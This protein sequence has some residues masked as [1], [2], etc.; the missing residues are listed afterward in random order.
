MKTKHLL[1]A[2]FILILTPFLWGQ[3]PQTMSYQGVLTD[4]N[5]VPV[6]DGNYNVTFRLYEGAT[7]GNPLWEE[8]QLIAATSGIFNVILGRVIPL[9]L[10]F[11]NPYWLG[12]TVAA[13]SE[14]TPRIQLTSSAYSLNAADAEKV[15]GFEVSA[16]P[17][18]N[19]LL[20][21][22]DSGKFPT[23]VLP[24]ISPVNIGGVQDPSTAIPINSTSNIGLLSFTISD[25]GTFN[26]FLN[27]HLTAE[28]LGDGTGQY[29]FTIRRGSLDG[30]VLGR[31]NW[32]PGSAEG[33][34]TV[35][36]SFTGID[37]N[38]NGPVT[39]FLVGK[40]IEPGAKDVTVFATAL[41]AIWTAKIK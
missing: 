19:T 29:W 31:G 13:G 40:K 22:D 39:Y 28:I 21:L 25:S 5:G 30:P 7:G 4:A 38:L 17:T 12:V 24:Q 6:P 36:V 32:M 33:F 14:L 23:D 1:T 15:G 34:N 2:L 27:A 10:A 35:T 3:I 18:A 37:M 26:V 9:N 41:N 20:P 8:A 11:D 16:T